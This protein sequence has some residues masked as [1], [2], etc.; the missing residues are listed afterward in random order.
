MFYLFREQ[1]EEHD[2]NLEKLHIAAIQG[3][4]RR[5][6]TRGVGVDDSDDDSEDD[7]NARAR[8]AMKKLRTSDRGDIKHLGT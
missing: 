4:L 1:E 8:R 2:Q 5:K 3:E 6:R 7:G